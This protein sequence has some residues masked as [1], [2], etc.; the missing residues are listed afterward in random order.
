L[1]AP[2][3]SVSRDSDDDSTTRDSD[4]DTGTGTGTGDSDDDTGDS[5][6]ELPRGVYCV[7]RR[8]KVYG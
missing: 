5:S 6:D 4:G 1:F 2:D 8:H 7:H 3:Y